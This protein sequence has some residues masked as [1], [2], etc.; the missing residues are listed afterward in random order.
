MAQHSPILGRYDGNNYFRQ[1]NIENYI[2][3][4]EYL[5][6]K[7][8]DVVYIAFDP[9]EQSIAFDIKKSFSDLEVLNT[10][11]IPEILSEYSQC[12]FSIGMKMHSNILSF[13]AGTPFISI[14]YDIKSPEFLKLIDYSNF[15]CNCFENYEDK[16]KNLIS[17]L[18]EHNREYSEKFINIK[19]K[20]QPIFEKEISNICEIIKINNEGYIQPPLLSVLMPVYNREKLIKPAIESILNQTFKEFEFLIY[21]DGSTDKTVECIE[22]YILKD[23]R[24]RLIRGVK[25]VGGI[26]AKQVLLNE[27]T[28][29]YAVW[30]DSDDIALPNKFKKQL[31]FIFGNSIVFC[32][33]LWLRPNGE[34]GWK[35]DYHNQKNLCFDSMMFIVDKNI[36]MPDSKLWGSSSWVNEMMHKYPN[37]IEIPEILYHIRQH[38]DRIT[39]VKRKVVNLI[40]E[41]K[42]KESDIQNLTYQELT[43]FLK[44]LDE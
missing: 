3:I 43:K 29:K 34:N 41:N 14:Y 36:N 37:W 5:K 10:D 19:G 2:K 24:I 18:I 13:A 27:C 25:N 16:V 15:G 40:K 28:T 1:K 21:D 22:E 30:Q 12:L 6:S 8:F 11:N 23:K 26:Y 38:D 33:W 44:D 7:T 20:N 9:V 4:C 31:N 39:L 42:I 35:A 17:E 32:K